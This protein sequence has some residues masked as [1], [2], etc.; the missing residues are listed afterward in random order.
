[1]PSLP[2]ISASDAVRALQRLGFIVVRQ[3]GSHIILR[4][5]S[6]GCVVPNHREIKTGTL[7]GLLKQGGVSISDFIN[8]LSS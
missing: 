6:Q 3:R 2:V 7:A 1:M 5:G 8:A 4:K